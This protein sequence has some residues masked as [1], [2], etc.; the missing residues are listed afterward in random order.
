MRI[1]KFSTAVTCTDA[2]LLLVLVMLPSNVGAQGSNYPTKVSSPP[3][4]IQHVEPRSF[5][6]NLKPRIKKQLRRLALL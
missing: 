1:D 2:I 4:H 5:S 3:S 6:K